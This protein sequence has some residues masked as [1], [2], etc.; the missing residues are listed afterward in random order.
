MTVD[1]VCFSVRVQ[2]EQLGVKSY[3]PL[4]TV[5]MQYISLGHEPPKVNQVV[6]R[7]VS[8]SLQTFF[9]LEVKYSVLLFI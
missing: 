6:Y 5:R 7:L 3:G 1:G 8:I 2:A 4:H 9:D